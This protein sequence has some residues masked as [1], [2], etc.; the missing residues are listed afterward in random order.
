M[1]VN[2]L[3]FYDTLWSFHVICLYIYMFIY[4]FV[5]V[6]IH[7]CLQALILENKVTKRWDLTSQISFMVQ[8]INFT[9][10][11]YAQPAKRVITTIHNTQNRSAKP[12]H[13]NNKSHAQGYAGA[14]GSE[15]QWAIINAVEHCL[16]AQSLIS[17]KE[18]GGTSYPPQPFLC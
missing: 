10:L 4:L 6:V 17:A 18:E 12:K 8:K 5:E 3:S 16:S 7:L 2:Y 11:L 15:S 13:Y 1:S 14:R 9:M